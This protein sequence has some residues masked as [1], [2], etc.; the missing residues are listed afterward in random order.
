[1][2]RSFSRLFAKELVGVGST[3]KN[4]TFA[5]HRNVMNLMDKRGA[6]PT[7]VFIAPNAS[8][9]G[10]VL[11]SN[12]V[13]IWYG[14]VLRADKNK[15]EINYSTAIMDRAV[16]STVPSLSSGFPAVLHI[17]EE[18]I[19]GPGS[20][21][22]SCDIGDNVVVG[23]GAII[24]EGSVIENN[25]YIAPGSVVPSGTFIP[26]GQLWAGNPAV[27]VR[28]VSGYEQ[29]VRY[30]QIDSTYGL[31]K[32]HDEEFLPYPSNYYHAE[33]DANLI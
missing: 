14:A 33:E 2:K 9:I 15:M 25:C 3:V 22:T 24:G 18:C 28:D 19:I 6:I 16:L 4:E 23:A 13:S 8:V 20:I 31:S 32:Q 21:I 29:D 12:K 30:K 1:M 5:R 7:G 27:Y 10:E 17:G 26:S 11:V